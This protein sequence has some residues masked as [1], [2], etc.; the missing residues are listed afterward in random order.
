MV[1]MIFFAIM[2][3]KLF[4]ASDMNLNKTMYRMRFFD[5]LISNGLRG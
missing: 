4:I 3:D 5:K 2:A 1:L